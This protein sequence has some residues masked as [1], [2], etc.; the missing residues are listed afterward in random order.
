MSDNPLAQFTEGFTKPVSKVAIALIDKIADATGMLYDPIRITRGAKAETKAGKIKAKG[1]IEIATSKSEVAIIQAES[2]IEIDKA[3]AEGEI[4]IAKAQAAVA[5]IQAEPEIE[6]TDLQQRTAYRLFQEATKQQKNME[7]T[8]AKAIPQLN[9][10]ADPNAIEDDWIAKF[11]DKC[12]LVSDD[13]MQDVWASILAGEANCAESY[14]QKTLTALAD[15]D[16]KIAILFQKFC[17]MCIVLDVIIEGV[18]FDARVLTLGKDPKKDG[19]KKY[20]LS[21]RDLNRLEAY[22]LIIPDYSSLRN[23]RGVRVYQGNRVISSFSYRG[24]SWV[25]QPFDTQE[26]HE[27]C[28]MPGVALSMIGSELF[29]IVEQIPEE[30]YSRVNVYNEDLI[31][32]LEE[33]GLEMIEFS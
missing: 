13:K 29:R 26:V 24:E 23:Y 3:K 14:S 1:E 25:F 11:F 27:D 32:Y 8:T 33:Q 21:F 6:I 12:R 30:P 9:E 28:I 7:N 2:E 20:D 19:L 17:S 16:Q 18:I 22:G 4:E 31:G 5:I 10:D 15:M